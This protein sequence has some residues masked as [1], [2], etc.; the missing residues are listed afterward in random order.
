LCSAAA[1]R[2]IDVIPIDR[3]T[4]KIVVPQAIQIAFAAVDENAIEK[5]AQVL[6]GVVTDL[7]GPKSISNHPR[8]Q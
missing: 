4:R 3:Y 1:R 8:I 7:D 5:G 6:V 2:N